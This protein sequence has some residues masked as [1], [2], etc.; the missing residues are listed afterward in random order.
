MVTTAVM[1]K[2]SAARELP[3]GVPTAIADRHRSRKR[4]QMIWQEQC[5][6][7]PRH[8]PSLKPKKTAFMEF[9]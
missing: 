5:G 3:P 7:N 8:E 2:S 6:P 9:Q 4:R 1:L